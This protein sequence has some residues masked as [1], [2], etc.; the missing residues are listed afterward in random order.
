MRAHKHPWAS[1]GG[2]P[3][4]VS[5]NPQL[6]IERPVSDHIHLR[7]TEDSAQRPDSA[8]SLTQGAAGR[9]ACRRL[10]NPDQV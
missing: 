8:L 5:R 6:Q 1:G 9:A 2:P 4:G 7:R 10:R 3:L